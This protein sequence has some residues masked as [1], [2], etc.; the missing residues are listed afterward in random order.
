MYVF[1]ASAFYAVVH[2]NKVGEMENQCTSHNSI[3]LAIHVLKLSN[4][5]EI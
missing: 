4:L 5:V 1:G 3:V 2:R